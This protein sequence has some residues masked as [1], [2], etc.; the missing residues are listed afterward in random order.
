MDQDTDEAAMASGSG[1]ITGASATAGLRPEVRAHLLELQ[2]FV[3]EVR[4][5]D[6]EGTDPE[7]TF[8]PRWPVNDTEP[9]T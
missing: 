5:L 3:S 7:A 9:L 6:I 8:D 1:D 4:V 2:R